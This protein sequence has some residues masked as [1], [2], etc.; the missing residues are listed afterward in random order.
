MPMLEQCMHDTLQDGGV[1]LV[2]TTRENVSPSLV[3]ELLRRIGGIIKACPAA[4][5]MQCALHHDRAPGVTITSLQSMHIHTFHLQ[6]RK[7]QRMGAGDRNKGPWHSACLECQ[8]G[9]R[10]QQVLWA[11]EQAIRSI[12]QGLHYGKGVGMAEGSCGGDTNGY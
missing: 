6:H 7:A 3:L 11:S 5:G 9:E 1:F 8:E 4:L 10:G 2:A 12:L